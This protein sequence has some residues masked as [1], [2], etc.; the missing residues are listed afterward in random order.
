MVL[1]MHR[2]RIL[3]ELARRGSVNGAAAALHLTPSA[4]SQQLSILQKQVG[5]RL[6]TPVGRQVQLTDSGRV[7]ARHAQRI[8]DE[9]R[10]AWI[11]LEKE[12]DTEIGRA[13]CRERVGS[14][15]GGA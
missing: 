5:R 2:L 9:E 4:V 11:A 7:L 14:A 1:S 12:Q 8:L 13:S 3:H 10:E 15:G 6:L